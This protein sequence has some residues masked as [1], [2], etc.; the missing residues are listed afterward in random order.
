M[1]LRSLIQI[2]CHVRTSYFLFGRPVRIFTFYRPMRVMFVSVWSTQY[3]CLHTPASIFSLGFLFKYLRSKKNYLDL[4]YDFYSGHLTSSY[5][6]S[7]EH[8]L[9]IQVQTSLL[10]GSWRKHT[11]N[12]WTK[13]T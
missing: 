1:Y 10:F 9:Y 3:F 13:K 7:F 4:D 8:V 2:F 6:N 11:K 5:V 12:G